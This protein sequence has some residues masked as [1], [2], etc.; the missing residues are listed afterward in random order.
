MSSNTRRASGPHFCIFADM[1]FV[2]PHQLL[3]FGL[4]VAAPLIF[5]LTIYPSNGLHVFGDFYLEFPSFSETFL[6]A[7]DSLEVNVPGIR[8]V[9][10]ADLLQHKRDSL[11]VLRM[12]IRYPD[13]DPS[14][15]YDLFASLS[16]LDSSGR[17]IHIL[18]F[19]GSQIEGD[20]I[21][22]HLRADFQARFGGTGP[23]WLPAVPYVG[24]RSFLI[25]YSDNWKRHA[26]YGLVDSTIQHNHFG[27]LGIYAQFAEE[28]DSVQTDTTT[29]EAWIEYKSRFGADE[30]VKTFK[31]IA[32]FY[33]YNRDTVR[34]RLIGG[35]DTL[36]ETLLSPT[37]RTEAFTYQLRRPRRDIR[38]EFSGSVSPEIYGVSLK[39]SS[40]INVSN[41]SMR[42][43]S[44]THFWTQPQQQLKEMFEA[45]DV[46]LIILQ[47]GANVVPYMDTE[48]EISEYAQ[49][50]GQNIEYLKRLIPGVSVIVIGPA[51]MAEKQGT[52]WVSYLLLPQLRD[53]MKQTAFKAG[54]AYW[55]PYAA[56]GGA[57]KIMEW[58][59]AN[60]PLAASDHVHFTIDGAE[61]I[62][63]WFYDAFIQDYE[64]YLE[65]R[66]GQ[67]F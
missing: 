64:N 27:A 49:R 62:A 59:N 39:G 54:A 66:A 4:L 20:R 50:F 28:S 10:D 61:V 21:T 3:A 8:G 67:Q 6:P 31:N 56:M 58:V 46:R 17:S 18:H 24:S 33:G 37:E 34:L 38:L 12:Q 9:D 13:H 65:W 5:L 48:E 35:K 47:Y 29:K 53:V 63:R 52:K 25:E 22:E 30:H 40:G 60:P 45:S 42:G 41:I 43:Q 57:G 23:G 2:K 51:D 32:L 11:Q 7:T 26:L 19:G 44:G 15:F 16:E 36:A 1:G 55:D 14:L